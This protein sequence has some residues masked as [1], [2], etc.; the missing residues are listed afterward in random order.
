[1]AEQV[2]LGI[3]GTT[4][5]PHVARAIRLA[6]DQRGVLVEQ[7]QPGGPAD[8]AHVRAGATPLVVNGKRWWLGGDVILAVNGTPV[9]GVQ[10]IKAFLRHTHPGQ[11][12]HL[13]LLR[14]GDLAQA[15]VTLGNRPAFVPASN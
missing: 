2:W 3:L 5:T 10:D 15:K 7:L 6:S 1:M 13:T 8:Q 12:V 9:A 11:T 14:D 4:V